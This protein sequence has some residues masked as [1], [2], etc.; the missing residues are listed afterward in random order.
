MLAQV[1]K[2]YREKYD[3]TQEQL[4]S[5]LNVDPRTIRRWE[6]QETVLK[7]KEELRRLASKLGVEAE[8]FGVTSGSISEQQASETLEHI[9]KLVNGGRAWE[10]RAIAECLAND[11]QTRARQTGKHEHIYRLTLAHHAA[12][13]TKAMNT[14][15]SEI[16]FPLASYHQMGETAQAIND[17]GLLA[18][19]LTYEGD[20]YNR[21]GKVEKGIPLLKAAIDTTPT[22]DIAAR[23]NALQLLGRAYLKAGDV[24]EF[25]R[26]MKEAEE[27]AGKLDGKEVTRGQYGLISVYEE[28]SKSYALL[29]ETKKSLDYLQKA[30]ALGVPD[31][32]WEMVLKTTKVIALVRGGEIQAGTTLALECIEEC[33]KYGTIRLLERMYGVHIY[34]QRLR[35]QIGQTADVLRDAL[36]GPIEF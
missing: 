14:R 33:R 6:N 9:W 10:A 3:L 4:A 12:A 16:K 27:L 5:D 21:T 35:Q 36:D 22:N 31:T 28:Y 24:E 7:D 11:L 20:M 34:L 13:Y 25:E 23:G 15:I 26:V 1:L 30:Y 19:A 8:R 2:E 29:G 17:T 18:I 32:H